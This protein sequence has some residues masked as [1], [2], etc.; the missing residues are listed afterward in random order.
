MNESLILSESM[1]LSVAIIVFVMMG[2]GLALTV[3]EFRYGQPRREDRLVRQ[4][5]STPRRRQLAE[6]AEDAARST[7]ASST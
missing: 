3:W 5:E 7:V 6:A 2:I 4:R 1:L